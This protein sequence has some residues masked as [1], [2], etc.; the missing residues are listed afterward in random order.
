M[1]NA[2]ANID[3]ECSIGGDLKLFVDW[4]GL[5]PLG[6]NQL[7]IHGHNGVK[8]FLIFWM[9]GQPFKGILFGFVGVLERRISSVTWIGVVSLFEVF[10]QEKRGFHVEIAAEDIY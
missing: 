9:A 10:V 5:V 8:G 2:T 6:L 4:E 3:E 7:P 1:A